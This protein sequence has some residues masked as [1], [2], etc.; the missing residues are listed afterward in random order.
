LAEYKQADE[1]TG[2]YLLCNITVTE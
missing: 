2:F 1:R